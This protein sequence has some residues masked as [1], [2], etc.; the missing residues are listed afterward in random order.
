MDRDNSSM[1]L[2]IFHHNSNVMEILF[3][4]HPNPYEVIDTKY[5]MWHDSYAVDACAEILPWYQYQQLN[6]LNKIS[7]ESELWWKAS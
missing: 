2:A 4:F 5:C 1:S 7:I 3:Y 6:Q